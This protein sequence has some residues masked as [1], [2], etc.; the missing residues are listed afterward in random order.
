MPAPVPTPILRFIHVDN[1]HICLRRRGLHAPKHTPDDGLVYR[2]IHNVDIQQHRRVRRIPCGPGGVVHNYVPF[3]FGYLSPMMLQLHTG[4]VEGYTDGQEP[5]VYLVATAQD[6]RD[7]GA[8]FAFSDGH[9]VAAFTQWFDDRDRLDTVDWNMVY[10]RYWA[11]NLDD[12]D[13]Q[14]R[15]QA[16]FLVH[17][18]CE[19][20]LIREIAVIDTGVKRQVEGILSQFAPELHRPVR[21]RGEWYYY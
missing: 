2:T 15:K 6:V 1:L 11:D 17:Q 12:M 13:R 20:E 4:Q 8:G 14:R 7:T 3:Y 21:V 10:Q 18:F 16:E 9:G 19:W 5:L